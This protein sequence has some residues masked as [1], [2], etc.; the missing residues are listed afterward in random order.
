MNVRLVLMRTHTSS[1]YTSVG[2]NRNLSQDSLVILVIQTV[3]EVDCPYTEEDT[4]G[5]E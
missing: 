5:E 4:G 2:F 3:I 1:F